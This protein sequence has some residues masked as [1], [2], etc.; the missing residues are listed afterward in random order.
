MPSRSTRLDNLP[1]YV[2]SRINDRIRDLQARG[3]DVLRLDIG[4][5]DMPPPDAVIDTLVASARQNGNHSYT[6]YRGTTPFRKAIAEYYLSRFGVNLNPDTEVLPLIGSKE[7][8]VNLSLA[9]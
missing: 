7:G 9:Y 3:I 1:T 4:S 6:G 8:I 2:F 5:P